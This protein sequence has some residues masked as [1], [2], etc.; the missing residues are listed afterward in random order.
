M[1]LGNSIKNLKYNSKKY[2][3]EF[4]INMNL[5]NI[6]ST[7]KSTPFPLSQINPNCLEGIQKDI[8]I[9]NSVTMEDI[10]FITKRFETLNLFRGCSSGCSHC[11]KDA[12]PIKNGT[13]LFEDLKNFLNGFKTLNERLGFNVFQGNKY[14]SIIDDSNPF[15]I[16]IRGETRLHSVNE[17]VKMI[18]E[19]IKLPTIFVTSGWNRGSKYSQKTTEEFA[20]MVEKN[21]EMI[22]SVE[23]SI[24]PFDGLME[25]SRK[26]LNSENADKAEFFR[27]IYTDR[28]A[29]ALNVFL[30]LFETGKARVIYR[31]A[32]DFPGNELVGEHATAQLY[33][34]IY[35]KLKQMT[36]SLLENIQA[37]KPENLT[38]FDKSHLIESSGRGRRFFPNQ[39]NLKEQEELIEEVLYRDSMSPQER[40]KE[41][42]DCSVK[43][44]DINGKVYATMP[45][46]KVDYISAPIELTFPTDI[47]LNYKNKTS[48]PPVFSEI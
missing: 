44:I 30:K 8:P 9:F 42:L 40:H 23:V 4:Y 46:T 22:E 17:A 19:K 20:K 7:V 25:K 31:H 39:H 14:L 32:P 43:C 38:N 35:S 2:F 5:S 24:N 28:I 41:L 15:D 18:Y 47:K 11:L 37:L 16:P 45:A 10:A 21:P 36:G 13:I 33:S 48:V 3:Y 34:E 1:E 26:A 29:N 12:K 27:N 6:S